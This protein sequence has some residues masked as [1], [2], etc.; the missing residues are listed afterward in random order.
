MLV[1]DA[2]IALDAGTYRLREPLAGSA[3]GV[4]WRAQPLSGMPDVALKLINRTQMEGAAPLQRERW[5]ASAHNEI[6]FLSALAP[7]DERHIVRLLDSGAHEGLPV[8][9]LELM[10]ADLGR[11]LAAERRAGRALP[12]GQMLDWMEQVNQALA[13]VHQYGWQYLD[14]KPANVLLGRQGGV[15]LAD[16]GTN[17]PS[18]DGPAASYAG[19]ANWQAPEQF[20]PAPDGHYATSIGTD[21]F[22][23]GA[24]FYFL[25][26]GGL[27]LRFCSDCGHAYRE[28]QADAASRLLARHQGQLPA[29]LHDDEAALFAHRIDSQYRSAHDATWHAGADGGSA[30]ALSLLRALLA[31]NPAGRPAHALQISRMLGR[32]RAALPAVRHA[33]VPR[34][35]ASH[36]PALRAAS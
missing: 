11:H 3:Y 36:G 1:A 12:F 32:A 17:R 25:V 30:A 4:V 8:L 13:K 10:A 31:P 18:A 20:F 9:A 22:A 6:A 29:T 5:I 2:L 27:P 28:H 23:L 14:L 15:K 24:M 35:L 16:F 7:W 33:P 19:T 34:M 21:Y 26:T